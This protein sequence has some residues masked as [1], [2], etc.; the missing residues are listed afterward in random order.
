G[1]L[2]MIVSNPPY[3]EAG[4]IPDLPPEV[5]AFDPMEALDGGA[6]GLDAVRIIASEGSKLLVH[7]GWVVLELGEGQPEPAAEIFRGVGGYDRFR[8]EKDLAGI[9]RYLLVRK[10]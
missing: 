7:G 9:D 2:G 3:I 10:G 8:V 1:S 5:R 4:E 6:D